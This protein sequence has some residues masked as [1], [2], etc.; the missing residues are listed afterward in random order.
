MRIRVKIC[1]ITRTEDA[2][3]AVRRGADAVGL[4]FYPGSPRFVSVEQAR[5]IVDTV[6]PF[7]TVVG[8]FVNPDPAQV[9]DVIGRLPLG[10]LQFHGQETNA[11]CKAYGMPFIKSRCRIILQRH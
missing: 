8:L 6:S 4:V 9:R 11:D 1:G 2:Q 10:L 3:D 7:V 5:S